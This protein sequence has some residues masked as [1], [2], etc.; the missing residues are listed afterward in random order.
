MQ[1]EHIHH[2]INILDWH[3][4]ITLAPAVNLFSLFMIEFPFFCIEAVQL[5]PLEKPP[6]A[7]GSGRSCGD[8]TNTFNDIHGCQLINNEWDCFICVFVF[9]TLKVA[10]DMTHEERRWLFKTHKFWWIMLYLRSLD[11]L[12]LLLRPTSSQCFIVLFK[13]ASCISLIVVM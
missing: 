13:I 9:G 7:V 10:S 3:H 12:T 8:D 5:G 4:W 6:R 11:L 2:E 1:V